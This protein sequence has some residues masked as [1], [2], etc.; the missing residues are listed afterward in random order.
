MEN[1]QTTFG[2]EEFKSFMETEEGRKVLNPLFDSKVSKAI[3]TWKTNNL[4]KVVN[5]ELVK[6]GFIQTEEQKAMMELKQEI[7]NMKR[8]KQIAE[9]NNVKLSELS[10]NGLPT[11]F[12]KYIVGD[13]EEAIRE[14]ILGMKE[15]FDTTVTET[16]KKKLANTGGTIEDKKPPVVPQNL[17][18]NKMTY[19]ERAKLKSENPQLFNQLMGL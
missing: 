13:S 16:V 3:D 17:D 1:P 6:Q 12:S 14:S 11:T 15:L 9:L 19:T 4:E 8:D 5:D 2:V 10:T 18:I 7:E